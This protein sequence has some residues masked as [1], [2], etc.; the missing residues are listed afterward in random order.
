[1]NDLNYITNNIYAF[2]HYVYEKQSYYSIIPFYT[3]ELLK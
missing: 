2:F 3:K 1:M